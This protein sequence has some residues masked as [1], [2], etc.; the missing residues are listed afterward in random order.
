MARDNTKDLSVIIGQENISSYESKLP[1]DSKG[2]SNC[3][4]NCKLSSKMTEESRYTT[5]TEVPG[6]RL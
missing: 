6:S 3:T 5:K 1:L 2:T 4:D